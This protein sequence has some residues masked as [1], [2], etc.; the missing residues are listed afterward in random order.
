MKH[1]RL[2]HRPAPATIGRTIHHLSLPNNTRNI[3]ADQ[4]T[5]KIIGRVG[6]ERLGRF[7]HDELVYEVEITRGSDTVLEQVE[8]RH[9]LDFVTLQQLECFEN[10][11]FEQE[12]TLETPLPI[13]PQKKRG[14]PLKRAFH[15]VGLSSDEESVSSDVIEDG[16]AAILPIAQDPWRS[17]SSQR[18]RGRPPAAKKLKVDPSSSRL[19]RRGNADYIHV[20]LPQVKKRIQKSLPGDNAQPSDSDDPIQA[21]KRDE[22]L[23]DEAIGDYSGFS[24]TSFEKPKERSANDQVNDLNSVPAGATSHFKSSEMVKASQQS[25]DTDEDLQPSHQTKPERGRPRRTPLTVVLSEEDD[26]E[27]L[28]KQF[29]VKRTDRPKQAVQLAPKTGYKVESSSEDE[30]HTIQQ[31]FGLFPP[32]PIPSLEGPNIPSSTKP[33]DAKLRILPRDKASGG[34][35]PKPSPGNRPGYVAPS[36]SKRPVAGDSSETIT[37]SRS[38]TSSSLR[39]DDTAAELDPSLSQRHSKNG[40]NDH[41]SSNESFPSSK[42]LLMVAPPSKQPQIASY[43]GSS[44]NSSS[45]TASS[46]ELKKASAPAS[47][48]LTRQ[49]RVRPDGMPSTT[50]SN[51]TVEPQEDTDSR[52]YQESSTDIKDSED[53]DMTAHIMEMEIPDIPSSNSFIPSGSSQSRS[54]SEQRIVQKGEVL[55]TKPRTSNNSVSHIKR[56]QSNLLP[57]ISNELTVQYTLNRPPGNFHQ[58]KLAASKNKLV[59]LKSKPAARKSKPAAPKTR[60]RI[61]MLKISRQVAERSREECEARKQ[62]QALVEAERLRSPPSTSST[63][64]DSDTDTTSPPARP[65]AQS[66]RRNH[67]PNHQLLCELQQQPPPMRKPL[68]STFHQPLPLHPQAALPL[69]P[70]PARLS[71]PPPLP[72]HPAPPHPRSSQEQWSSPSPPVPF[73]RE[74]SLSLGEPSPEPRTRREISIDLG[75]HE[76]SVKPPKSTGSESAAGKTNKKEKEVKK[77]RVRMTPLFPGYGGGSPVHKR[78]VFSTREFEGRG[79]Q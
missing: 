20:A 60:P 40:N 12:L 76:E 36:L 48:S 9:I 30:L 57:S 5:A 51:K 52:E 79:G 31:K 53:E 10:A 38:T 16:I 41:S 19:S 42:S 54:G 46:S 44:S 24:E 78:K 3:N 15:A 64:S 34:K 35:R 69:H 18:G 11:Q 1:K 47:R 8:C 67:T 43:I 23:Q 25:V 2:E 28:H 59:P 58:R 29:Q 13:I 61:S 45:P 26:L 63:S 75:M 14:R 33:S 68:P 4:Q 71:Q 21:L 37:S 50:A 56:V 27:S 77:K 7:Q 55:K 32:K 74:V 72:L 62:A 6:L 70:S 17:P 73:R 65:K 49:A 66:D 39:P 22:T